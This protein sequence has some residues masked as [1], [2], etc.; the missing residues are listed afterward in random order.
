M[1]GYLSGIHLILSP[2]R[3]S[4]DYARLIGHVIWSFNQCGIYLNDISRFLVYFAR[5]NSANRIRFICDL[6]RSRLALLSRLL[7]LGLSPVI[8]SINEFTSIQS[9]PLI[10]I[11]RITTANYLYNNSLTSILLALG[12]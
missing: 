10:M 4:I 1:L 7:G 9:K 11:L 6:S 8:G 12:N 2:S 3:A 5:I